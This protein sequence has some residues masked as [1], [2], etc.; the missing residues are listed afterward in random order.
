MTLIII[1]IIITTITSQKA[2][3]MVS[4]EISMDALLVNVQVSIDRE[5]A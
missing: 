2:T 4:L 1:I 5:N 3:T